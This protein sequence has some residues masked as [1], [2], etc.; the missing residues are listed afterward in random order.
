MMTK[1][2]GK[3]A[4]KLSPR[5]PDDS[6]KDSPI[7]RLA[8]DKQYH[9]DLDATGVGQMLSFRSA[10]QGSAGYVAIELVDGTLQGR[11]GTFVLQ[12]SSTMARGVPAQSITVIP[13]SATGNLQGLAGELTIEISDGEHFYDFSYSLPGE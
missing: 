8:I 9:G 12:H 11:S 2:H 7:G 4:V 13:D 6:A 10:T 5:E 3:F 1:I